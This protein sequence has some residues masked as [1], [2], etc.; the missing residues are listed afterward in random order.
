MLMA[1]VNTPQK[2]SSYINKVILTHSIPKMPLNIF[3]SGAF[4][5]E[6]SIYA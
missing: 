1:Y 5:F 2:L 6:T 4:S 3:Y